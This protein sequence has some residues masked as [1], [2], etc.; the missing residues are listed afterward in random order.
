[1]GVFG[2]EGRPKMIK[3]S[4]IAAAFSG[5]ALLVST[6]CPSGPADSPLTTYT[7]ERSGEALIVTLA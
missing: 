7:V 1:M 3:A 2:N 4:K 6:G 5:L